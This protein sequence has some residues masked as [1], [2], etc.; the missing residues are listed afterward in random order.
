[1]NE[2]LQKEIFAWLDALAAKL[3]VTANHLW[4][5]VVRQQYIDGVAIAFLAVL[6]L[7]ASCGG[8]LILR[9]ARTL[10]RRA[11][12]FP[13]W[14]GGCL[15]TALAFAGCVEASRAALTC[16]I[17]PE[18]AALRDLLGMLRGR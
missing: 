1:M 5:I 4:E 2:Q 17:N 11:D 13:Y 10:D 3:G 7:V 14:F 18:Y 15:L 12:S 6:L 16:F 8:V 9:H